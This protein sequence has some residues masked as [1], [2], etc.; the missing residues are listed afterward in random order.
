MGGSEQNAGSSAVE[1]AEQQ[2]VRLER[3]AEKQVEP[4]S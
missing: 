4:S 1:E 3:E 2:V